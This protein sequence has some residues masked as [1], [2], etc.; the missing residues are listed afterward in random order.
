MTPDHYKNNTV[1]VCGQNQTEG[2][3]RRAKNQY[4][5]L[6][7]DDILSKINNTLRL[8]DGPKERPPYNRNEVYG[9]P[10]IRIGIPGKAGI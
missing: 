9:V 5:I 10:H 1:K 7:G 3:K 4:T 8:L 6:R 2:V